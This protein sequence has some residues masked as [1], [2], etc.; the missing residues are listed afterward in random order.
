[1][2]FVVARFFPVAPPKT[3]LDCFLPL[4]TTFGIARGDTD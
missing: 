3:F 1:L 2:L 4:I